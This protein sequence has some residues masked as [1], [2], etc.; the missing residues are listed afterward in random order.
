V[1]DEGLV[2]AQGDT[3]LG[4]L[5]SSSGEIVVAGRN[6]QFRT[7]G[8]M[9][10]GILGTGRVEIG[11]QGLVRVGTIT[12]LGG[13]GL[14]EMAGGTLQSPV[15][16][17]NGVIR[18]DGRL[19]TELVVN[20]GDIRTAAGIS[21][22]RERL[23]ITGDLDNNNVIDSIGG[24]MEVEGLV[25][26]NAGALIY[27]RDA[28]FRFRGD[29]TG[30]GEVVLDNSIMEVP[31]AT[32]AF[33][34]IG[35]HG[36]SAVLG[37]LVLGGGTMAMTVGDDFSQLLVTGDAFLDGHLDVSLAS[38]YVPEDGDSFELIHNPNGVISGTFNTFSVDPTPGIFWL[39][40]YTDPESVFLNAF[41]G[42]APDPGIGADFDNSNLVD[43]LDLVIWKNNFGLDPATQADGD[44]NYDGVVD[45]SDFLKWQRQVGTDPVS[46]APVPEPSTVVLALF[47]LTISLT[48]TARRTRR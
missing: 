32:I 44:A 18:G 3:V 25:T 4:L 7:L 46:I 10:V 40:D 47:G 12:F 11:A 21:N 8:Q 30:P 35:P 15:V 19:Q 13:G 45:G 36:D 43:G 37:D 23:W 38:G 1:Y 20:D 24:E 17:N 39:V 34:E 42:V 9:D 41:A 22:L 33:L 27:G 31:I 2:F 16:D 6:S 29:I 14:I 5:G 26:N 48:T 28:V